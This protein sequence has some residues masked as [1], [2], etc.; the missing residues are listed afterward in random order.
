MMQRKVLMDNRWAGDTGIGRLCR[1][2]MKYAP[3]EADIHFISHKM[4]LGNLF[5]PLMLANEI[6][7]AKPDTFYSP[8][9]MPPFY[10]TVPFIFTVHD[11]MHLFYY[12]RLHRIYYQTVISRLAKKARKIITVSHFSKQQLIELLGL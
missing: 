8:S 10:C 1:E 12:T 5:S 9:F 6:R 3:Q 7:K 11:L 4:G 2:V